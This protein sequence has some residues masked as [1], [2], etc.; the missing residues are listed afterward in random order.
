MSHDTEELEDSPEFPNVGEIKCMHKQCVPGAPTFFVL[1]RD[2]A[3]T[4]H[5]PLQ[6]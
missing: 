4:D 5:A 6:K 1:T 2:E 3:S